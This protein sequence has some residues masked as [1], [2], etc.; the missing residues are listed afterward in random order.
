MP[1]DAPLAG[2]CLNEE[3][4]DEGSNIPL[5]KYYSSCITVCFVQT[6]GG[7]EAHETI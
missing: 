6:G 1:A 7:I 5:M 4:F 2:E 3:R